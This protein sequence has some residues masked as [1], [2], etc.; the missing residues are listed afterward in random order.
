MNIVLFF[1]L[2]VIGFSCSKA[3]QENNPYTTE[4]TEFEATPPAPYYDEKDQG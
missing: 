4:D 1:L 3:Q 2:A